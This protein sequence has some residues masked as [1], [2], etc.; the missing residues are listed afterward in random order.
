M[1]AYDLNFMHPQYG[2]TL[3]ASIDGHFTAKEMLHNLL[4]SGFIPPHDAGYRLE[5]MGQA[6]EDSTTFDEVPDLYDGALI[7]VAPVEQEVPASAQADEASI[8]FQLKH[9]E[10]AL[11]FSVQLSPNELLEEAIQK[12]AASHFVDGQE[13]VLHLQKGNKLLDLQQS[14][15]ENG[16]QSGDYLQLV[17]A[18]SPENPVRKELEALK[19]GFESLQQA[20][21]SELQ[22]FKAAL[23]AANTIPVDPTR[24]VNPTLETYE[25][26]DTIVG[27]LRQQS[28]EAPLKAIRPLSVGQLIVWLFLALL[29]IGAVVVMYFYILQ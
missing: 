12:A 2:T 22:N 26:I 6:L 28:Q 7:R 14:V 9:P 21:S 19:D 16:V 29:G 3:P 13:Q 10:S 11:L 5:F 23:P 20:L 4:L 8:E 15:S 18:E 17:Q 24:A 27:R 1:T 25:S